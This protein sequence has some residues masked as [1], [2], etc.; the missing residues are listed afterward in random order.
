MLLLLA[1]GQE[2]ASDSF[3]FPDLVVPNT[4]D[5]NV[6]AVNY[7]SCPSLNGMTSPVA[8]A[9]EAQGIKNVAC[10]AAVDT[11]PLTTTVGD[12]N[13]NIK[14]DN[15][16]SDQINNDLLY[17]PVGCMATCNDAKVWCDEQAVAWGTDV[18]SNTGTNGERNMYG[19]VQYTR[20]ST[21]HA[22]WRCHAT[23][24]ARA[25]DFDC[26]LTKGTGNAAVVSQVTRNVIIN[27]CAQVI[28]RCI[29]ALIHS[30]SH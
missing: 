3:V 19:S 28:D 11:N 27:P 16:C 15:V 9:L 22:A 2:A 26:I 7:L 13:T 17:T 24:D 21:G 14:R 25:S 20:G 23:P 6:D 18:T 30:L 8:Y 5:S 12:T 4:V 29:D 1:G 10:H